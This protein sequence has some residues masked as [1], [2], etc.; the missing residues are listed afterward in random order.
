MAKFILPLTAA[1][2][3]SFASAQQ[4]QQ[5]FGLDA[6][7]AR[8]LLTW[9]EAQGQL[10]GA[11]Q[12]LTG[13]ATASGPRVDVLNQVVRGTRSGSSYTFILENP[14]KFFGAS[15]LSGTLAKDTLSLMIPQST[16][17][18]TT[19]QLKTTTMAKFNTSVT[20]FKAVL[21]RQSQVLKQ[22]ADAEAERRRKAAELEVYLEYMQQAIDSTKTISQQI[23]T[24]VSRLEATRKQLQEALAEQR[25]VK[26][27]IE[28][29]ARDK[30]CYQFNE[31]IADVYLSVDPTEPFTEAPKSLETPLLALDNAVLNYGE[32][33]KKFLSLGG[34]AK[35]IPDERNIVHVS[36]QDKGK[37][38]TLITALASLIQ[39]VRDARQATRDSADTIKCSSL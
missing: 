7:Q 36:V 12:L 8:I 33:R 16:G 23:T 9:T 34:D 3:V 15:T 31:K 5:V 13:T 29:L 26:R 39:D 22:Q 19:F 37:Y 25:K 18:F 24:I 38:Q 4:G 28:Q 14:V 21:T 11:L 32:Y 27:E 17:G 6:P 35:L 30:E 1:L 20:D 2:C 10:S